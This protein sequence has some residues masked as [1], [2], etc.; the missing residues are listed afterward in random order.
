MSNQNNQNQNRGNQQRTGVD[1]KPVGFLYNVTDTDVVDF[2]TNY[3]V[4]KGFNSL[5]GVRAIVRRDGNSNPELKFVA[6]FPIDGQ[7]VLSDADNVPDWVRKQMEYSNL[8]LADSLY[9]TLR[10]IVNRNNFKVLRATS[11]LA[12]VELDVFRVFG[13]MLGANPQNHELFV[14]DV[15]RT[16]KTHFVAAIIKKD[17]LVNPAGGGEYDRL[18]SLAENL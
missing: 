13:L 11:E 7:G 15:R 16:K 8:R 14:T 5:S 10:P 17:K 6:F 3:L 12:A 18:T 4:N 1:I 9:N 2:V